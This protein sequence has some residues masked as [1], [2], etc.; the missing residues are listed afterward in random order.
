MQ[1]VG[2]VIIITIDIIVNNNK[3]VIYS[4]S[5]Y[6][7]YPLGKSSVL[8][9]VTYKSSDDIMFVIITKQ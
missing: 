5:L 8:F 7:F 3:L 9:V 4:F 6:T 2:I 1:A